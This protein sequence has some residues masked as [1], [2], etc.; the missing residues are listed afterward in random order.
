MSRFHSI[1]ELRYSLRSVSRS[2]PW[3]RQIHILTNCAP[4]D[5]LDVG[6]TKINWV[7]HEHIIPPEY[8]PTFSS[9]VIESYLH[10][11]PGLT[12]RFV[13]MND[14]VFLTAPKEKGFFFSESGNSR[15]FLEEGGM[16][17]GPIRTVDPDYLNASRN[18][19]IVSNQ[20]FR[21]IVL[22]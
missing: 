22:P 14:D 1:D 19:A 21:R 16:V 6:C 17:S 13:Y 3:F 2:L 4:P 15:A 8:L 12:E 10:H 20:T 5:W 7:K 9:H 11:I 18:S